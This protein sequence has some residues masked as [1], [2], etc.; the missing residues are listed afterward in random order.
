MEDISSASWLW[1]QLL[2]YSLE[3]AVTGAG[4]VMWMLFKGA[5][6]WPLRILYSLVSV[7]SLLMIWHALIEPK[8]PQRTPDLKEIET[9]ILDWSLQAG[10]QINR[11]TPREGEKLRYVLTGRKGGTTYVVVIYDPPA[12]YL[13]LSRT[14]T[15]SENHKKI[16]GSLSK[17]EKNTFGF[18]LTKE[19]INLGIQYNIRLPDTITLMVTIVI[20]QM[21]NPVRLLKGLFDI[22]NAVRVVKIVF[23]GRLEDKTNEEIEKG[24]F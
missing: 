24:T 14:I 8:I 17:Q 5:P 15:V 23:S 10:Y 22:K 2:D 6:T 21:R 7:A 11:E 3:L 13:L 9:K 20:D 16:L 1:Q 12:Y 18:A 19:I 4:F